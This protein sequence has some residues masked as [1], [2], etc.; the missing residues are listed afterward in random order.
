MTN[1]E[2]DRKFATAA[3]GVLSKPKCDAYLASIRGIE[4]V[5]DALVLADGSLAA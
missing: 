4:T 3:E 2:L 5:R 1:A